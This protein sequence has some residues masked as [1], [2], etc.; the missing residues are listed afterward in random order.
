MRRS[1]TMIVTIAGALAAM[2]IR[3]A[4]AQSPVPSTTPAAAGRTV[5]VDLSDIARA[6]GRWDGRRVLVRGEVDRVLDPHAL[7]LGLG[8]AH[9]AV[10]VLNPTPADAA[11]PQA[12]VTVV[13]TVR[14]Y[15]A[16]ELA[17]E[18]AWFRPAWFGASPAG[19]PPPAVVV[20]D[21]IRTATGIE[22]VRTP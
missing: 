18:H 5:A 9:P 15:V 3:S 10:V 20:A 14:P 2:A 19:T 17:R 16:D 12:T 11:N 13:G 22:L 7:T 6:P 21:S 1:W 4:T 8:G